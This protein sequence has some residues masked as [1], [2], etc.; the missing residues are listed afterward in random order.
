MLALVGASKGLIE[1]FQKQAE[2]ALQYKARGRAP[3]GPHDAVTVSSGR[4]QR[5][6]EG[7]VELTVNDVLTQMPAAKAREIGLMLLEA[8]EAAISDEIFIKLLAEVGVTEPQAQG[9]ILLKLRE[10]RQ[11]TRGVSWPI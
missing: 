8:S 9:N 4:G 7:F 3:D 11:G 6:G 2:F 5:T 1:K 10:L